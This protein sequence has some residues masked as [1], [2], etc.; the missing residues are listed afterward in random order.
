[1]EHGSEEEIPPP[2]NALSGARFAR[3]CEADFR[4]GQKQAIHRR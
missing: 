1:M 2:E 3:V 4:T